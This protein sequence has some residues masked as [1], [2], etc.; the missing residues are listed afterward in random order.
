MSSRKKRVLDY[1]KVAEKEEI[2]ENR[3]GI[4]K[5]AKGISFKTNF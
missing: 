4:I 3:K 1:M 5:E 2:P